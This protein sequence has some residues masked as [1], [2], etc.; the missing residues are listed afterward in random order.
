MICIL[1]NWLPFAAEKDVNRPMAEV[2]GVLIFAT[3]AV[4]HA[5]AYRSFRFLQGENK[6][7]RASAFARLGDKMTP[8]S[9]NTAPCPEALSPEGFRVCP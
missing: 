9:Q 2:N 3:A 5:L 7:F 1:Y 4:E 8:R 6:P